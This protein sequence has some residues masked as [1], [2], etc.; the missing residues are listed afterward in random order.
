MQVWIGTSGYSYS[1]W[2][3]SF[4]PSGTRPGRMLAH[5]C[6]TFPLVE[7]NFTFYRPPTGG[8]L[9][10]LADQ[11][12]PGFQFLVKL[13]QSLSHERDT[14]ELAGFRVAVE[15]LRRRNQLLGL[16]CQLPQSFHE[17][18]ENR[19]WLTLLARAFAGCPLAVEFRHSSWFREDVPAWLGEQGLDLVSVDVPDLPQLYPRGLV[20]SGSRVYVRFHSRNGRN[21]YAPDKDRYDYKY[22]DAEMTE[23]VEALQRASP[24]TE[25]ALLLFNNCHRSHAAENARRMQE[26]LPRLAPTLTLVGPL[27]KPGPGTRQG[28]FF[29]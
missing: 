10:R 6:E 15:D 29:T 28:A 21:W 14:Q 19:D 22:N 2:V 20:P 25:R 8:Q 5:Y 11:T 4:Y 26:L 3:G 12:P 16:L 18:G 1:D 17:N 24:Q 13:H 7:L 9:A 23:W 27:A